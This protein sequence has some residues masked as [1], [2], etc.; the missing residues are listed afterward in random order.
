MARLIDYLIVAAHL[1]NNK[2]LPRSFTQIHLGN[3]FRELV[4]EGGSSKPR[5]DDGVTTK[6]WDFCKFKDLE[7]T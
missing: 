4:L 2:E 1:N 6:V 5:E 3:Q 7:E